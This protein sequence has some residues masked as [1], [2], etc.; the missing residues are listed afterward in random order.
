ME[1]NP[2]FIKQLQMLIVTLIGA[3]VCCLGIWLLYKQM[4]A[5]K[6][7]R[8]GDLEVEGLG[9]KVKIVRSLPGTIIAL[10]GGIL[11]Y[12]SL[13]AGAERKVH[14]VTEEKTDESAT[15]PENVL[16][17]WLANAGALTGREE[18]F[19]TIKAI[20]AGAN[21]R[22]EN[23]VLTKAQTLEE[24][25]AE[26]Y[27]DKR[28]WP[29]VARINASRG[30][31]APDSA[32]STTKIPT[33]SVVEFWLPAK[34]S[35]RVTTY[36]EFVKV[37]GT[38][39]R[40]AYDELLNMIQDGMVASLQQDRTLTEKFRPQELSYATS[41]EEVDGQ[42]TINELALKYYRSK[43]YTALIRWRNSDVLPAT[44]KDTDLIPQGTQLLIP[45]F[46]L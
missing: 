6:V 36:D 35:K 37:R 24:L 20:T 7:Q 45:S 1:G 40:G 43:K 33:A 31:Y 17:V 22:A 39:L 5:P 29:L 23:K 10:L 30:Y 41:Y 16:P 25:A 8:A 9:L 34:N 2:V 42:T 38:D 46:L 19:A 4:T 32:T 14:R 13:N 26:K 15:T 27:G 21:F 12:W 11:V 28:Y 44:L 18:Y 3:G